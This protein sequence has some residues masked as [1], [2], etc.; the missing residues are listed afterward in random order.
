MTASRS[1]EIDNL[2]L[3]QQTVRQC[4]A[5][6]TPLVDYGLAHRFLGNPPPRIAVNL[7][8]Y[9]NIIEH[10]EQDFTVRVAAGARFGD[11]QTQLAATG[12]FLP[13]DADRDITIGEI[14]NHNVFGP[15]RVGYGSIRDLLMG[16]SYVDGNGDDIT[17]GGR[18]V[19][20]VAGYDVSKF[21]VGQMGEFGIIHQAVLRTYAIPQSIQTVQLSVENPIAIDPII[22]KWLVS[23]AAPNWL[24][25]NYTNSQWAI[26]L[27]YFGSET[28]CAA[29]LSALSEFIEPFAGLDLASTKNQTLLEDATQRI[30]M[31][32]WRRD[33]PAVVKIIVPPATTGSVAQAIVSWKPE[34]SRF[35]IDTL[36]AH[37]LI[38]VGGE[39]DKN[40]VTELDQHITKLINAVGG[41]RA[42]YRKPDD[43]TDSKPFAPIPTDYPMLNKLKQTMDPAGIFNPGRFLQAGDSSK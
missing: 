32:R 4:V 35:Q 10:Y 34:A 33:V 28:A 6:K 31:R 23:D 24:N 21:M 22:T 26:N 18:I 17:V 36:P 43:A 1:V 27:A 2:E 30:E 9:G 11:V 15:L 38:F 3:L 39:L 41:L 37:G 29:Q 16:L 40:K 42:W 5:E 25:M 8:Q 13:I 7:T 19:K 12:Q 20:N 14:I